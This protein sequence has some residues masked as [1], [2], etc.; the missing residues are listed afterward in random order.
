MRRTTFTICLIAASLAVTPAA[1][2]ATTARDLSARIRVDGFTDEFTDD[3]KVFGFNEQF[4]EPEESLSDSKWGENNDLNQ[5]RITWDQK[6][7]YLAGEG[8]I[9]DNNMILFIDSISGFGLGAMDSLNSW[10]RNFVFDSSAAS[11]GGG[12]TPDLF[13]ATWDG[14]TSP[15]LIVQER[16]QRVQDFTVGSGFFQ[17]SATFDKGTLGRSMEFAIPWRSVFLGPV[18][19]GTRDTVLVVGGVP[20]T[21]PRFPPGTVL[22]IAGVITAGPDGTGGPDSAPDNTRGHTDQSGDRV[23]V[24]NWAIV[25]IDRNDDTG[26]GG[27]GPDGIADWGVQPRERISF[28]FRPP[29]PASIART[30]RFSLAD[31]ELDR[32]A[33][34][35]DYGERVRLQPRIDPPPDPGNDFHQI[36]TVEIRAD[37]YDARGRYVRNLFPFF[38]RRVLETFQPAVDQWDGRDDDGRLVPPGVY[39][40]RVE[41]KDV[42][43]VNRAVVVVR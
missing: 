21:F 20:D 42:S 17:A 39:I 40:I 33:F 32:K 4:E 5:I 29:I 30:L 31:V 13:C 9:W 24:D 41:L 12:L 18:G 37:V 15:R 10:R 26:L 35:P 7:L 43:R 14:N 2:P 34:R 27:G 19:R 38:G 28:R 36:T 16:A 8:R 11:L 22:K 3:E 23:V 1:A 25:E 6:F